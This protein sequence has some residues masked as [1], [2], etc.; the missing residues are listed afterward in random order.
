M[1]RRIG[2][3][4]AVTGMVLIVG[5]AAMLLYVEKLKSETKGENNADTGDKIEIVDFSA[6]TSGTHENNT[7]ANSD[8]EKAQ[9]ITDSYEETDVLMYN[10]ALSLGQ[11]ALLAECADKGRV[12]F[13]F[14]GDI[15]FDESYTIMNQY[16]IEGSNVN[17]AFL[18]GLLDRMRTADVFMINNEFPFS[19]RGE[20]VEGKKFTFR[21][22]P[23]HVGIY[24]EIG[25]DLVSLANNHAYDYGNDALLDT[26]DT[27]DAAGIPYVGAGRNID[28]ATKPVYV[29]ANGMKIAIVSATQIE[30][31]LPTHTKEATSSSAGVLRCL[32][33]S[34]LLKV[35]EEAKENSDFVILYIHWGSEGA[36]EI[37]W[38]QR[39]QAIVYAKAGVDL[40]IGNHTHCLQQLDL[41]EG[42]P[43]A[44]SLGN[45][46]FNSKAQD[47]CLIETAFSKDGIES[48]RFIPC[49]QENCRTTLLAG[50]EA[51][52]VLNYMRLISPNVEID[53]EGYVTFR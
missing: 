42:V 4:F 22:D 25:V 38:L 12:T 27:L 46:W 34:A 44:Y 48:I 7:A 45:F 3:F 35:I 24:N 18:E 11:K 13:A 31:N 51:D 10:E 30:R 21:A 6:D 19:T 43:V 29:I 28:E 53:A 1:G 52:R 36:E 37:D 2:I 8:G 26:F 49:R 20:P 50:A 9:I 14:A 5:M 15:M 23:K 33:P 41:V 47:T 16:I 17:N 39:D 40:I 32:D